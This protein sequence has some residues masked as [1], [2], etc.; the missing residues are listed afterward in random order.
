MSEKVNIVFQSTKTYTHAVGLST[1]FRQHKAKS[2]CRFL[3]GYALQVKLKFEASELDDNNWVQDFGGLKNIKSW[4]EEQFDHKTVVAEDDPELDVF[5]ELAAKG[6]LELTI[7][8]KVSLER[9]AEHVFN[10]VQE[11]LDFHQ[12]G[13]A[14]RVRLMEVEVHEH[15]GNSAI[16]MRGSQSLQ[17]V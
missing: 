7:L 8:P 3:H 13:T 5:V 10:H 4:L 15:S 16:A 6:I 2:H 9:F 1:C 14:Q 17:T 11:W 12:R